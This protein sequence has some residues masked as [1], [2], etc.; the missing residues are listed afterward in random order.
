MNL[1]TMVGHT[2]DR[3]RRD[4]DHV[5]GA[6]SS[7]GGL[8]K[9]GACTNTHSGGTTLAAGTLSLANNQALGTRAL[10]TTARW[11]HQQQA[12]PVR[13]GDPRHPDASQG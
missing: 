9:I 1:F 12:H 4:L 10:A 6:I 7:T 11:R 5:F 8:A 2:D 13:G 3:Q